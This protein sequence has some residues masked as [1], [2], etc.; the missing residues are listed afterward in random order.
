VQ[1]LT[2]SNESLAFWAIGE[3]STYSVDPFGLISVL[4]G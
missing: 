2:I 4:N 1:R 3:S